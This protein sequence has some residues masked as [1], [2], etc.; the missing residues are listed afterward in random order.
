MVLNITS[1]QEKQMS[2]GRS[3]GQAM[4]AQRKDESS[5]SAYLLSCFLLCAIRAEN[6]RIKPTMYT[7]KY[8]LV[9]YVFS[10]CF[11]KMSDLKIRQI[12]Y[13]FAH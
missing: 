5:I 1:P 4:A 3:I 8:M 13:F 12:V 9:P 6:E 7:T 10:K 2:E 11:D